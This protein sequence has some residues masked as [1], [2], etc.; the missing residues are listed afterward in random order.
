MP[1]SNDNIQIALIGAGGMGQ[2]DAHLATSI[3]GVKLIAASDCYDGRL[4]HMKEVYSPD[5]FTTRDYR[6][7]LA[8]PGIDAV[9]V[10]TP[11][12]WHR[13]I[14]VDALNAGKHVYCEK[15]MVHAIEEGKSIIDAQAKSGK[16][17]QVGSQYRSSLTYLKARELFQSNVIGELN[18]VEAWL[19]RNTAIGAWEYSIPLDANIQTCDW[20]QFQGSAS[21]HPWDPKRFFRWRNYR[22]YGTGVAGD[23]F[24]H[25]LTGLHTVTGSVGPNRVYATGGLRFWKDGRDVPDVMLATL[26]YP[27]RDEHP[28]FN[29]LLRVNFKS[30]LPEESFGVKFIG[31]EGVMTTGYRGI[32]I[33]RTPRPD[34]FDYTIESLPDATQQ[35]LRTEWQQKHGSAALDLKPDSTQTY[36]TAGQN[37]QLEHHRNFYRS[38]RDGS[39]LIEDATFGLRAAGPALLTNESYF[40][41]KIVFWD[42]EAM[43]QVH[44]A[45]A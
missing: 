30:S 37:A 27:K 39:P 44:G 16:V 18:S 2:G 4:Q 26:D 38:I 8:R 36:D 40:N 10:A 15:P 6:E 12:H 43:T 22:D 42:A 34:E 25:L 20:S 19:D 5:T 32:K 13:H 14:S 3:P 35:Q 45:D 11:D 7:I 28:A 1:S 33:E 17:F 24:V 29:V 9:I 41:K 31:S 21:K 23:L